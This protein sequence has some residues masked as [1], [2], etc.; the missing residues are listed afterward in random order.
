[1]AKTRRDFTPEFKR[2]AV[3][4]LDSSGRPQMQIAAE[5]GIQPPMLRHWRAVLNGGALAQIVEVLA[6]Q[7]PDALLL[8]PDGFIVANGQPVLAYAMSQ[9]L[10]VIS[11]WG[12][13]ADAGA[14][15]TY[16]L[17]LVEAYRRCG[18]YIDKIL[19]GTRVADLP[20]ERSTAVELGVNLTT[21]AR[22]SMTLPSTICCAANG[23]K[24]TR[25]KS[26]MTGNGRKRCW[27]LLMARS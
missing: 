19:K 13:L 20:I 8:L 14:P 15:I 12:L 3:A 23:F 7:P 11:G 27:M 16:G 2:E 6:R 5:L 18:Y 25:T 1:M 17:R 4:L 24:R 9:K 10:P 21:A 26:T 22:L